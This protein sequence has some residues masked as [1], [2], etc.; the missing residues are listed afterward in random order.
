M[1]IDALA[2]ID[3]DGSKYSLDYVSVSLSSVSCHV[4]CPLEAW[5][6]TRVCKRGEREQEI[7][8]V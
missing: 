7:F 2:Y 6:V 3:K 5:Q 1:E 8:H 4:L